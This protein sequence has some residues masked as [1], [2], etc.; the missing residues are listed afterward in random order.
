MTRS[1]G[2]DYEDGP[3]D[4][5]AAL[6]GKEL[7]QNGRQGQLWRSRGNHLK[8]SGPFPKSTEKPLRQR[9]SRLRCSVLENHSGGM[10]WQRAR[11]KAKESG[12]ETPET[13]QAG[14]DGGL[15]EGVER[16]REI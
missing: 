2:Y 9:S 12:L 5:R 13:I 16:E 10:L 4:R 1:Q 3:S 8:E 7:G 11:M 15:N 6:A 14:E